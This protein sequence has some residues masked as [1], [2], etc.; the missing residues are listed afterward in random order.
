MSV[1]HTK[2]TIFSDAGA[3]TGWETMS[4][5]LNPYPPIPEEDL[6]NCHAYEGMDRI[7]VTKRG[8]FIRQPSGEWRMIVTPESIS[9]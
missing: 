3:V 1:S 8:V 2:A 4:E 7:V 5:G 6:R 9:G